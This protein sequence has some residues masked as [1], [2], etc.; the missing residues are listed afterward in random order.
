[1]RCPSAAE[2][3]GAWERGL[4]Q[5]PAERGLTLLGAVLPEAASQDLARLSIGRRDAYLLSL[6][7]QA[8]GPKL[9]S[10]ATCPACSERVEL[11]LSTQDLRALSAADASGVSEA[12]GDEL[13]LDVGDYAVHC[14]LPNT[15]DLLAVAET[16]EPEAARSA[17]VDRC[18]LT[19]ERRGEAIPPAELPPGVAEAVVA[20]MSEADQQADVR[21]AMACPGCGHRWEAAFDILS[22]LWREL[23]AWAVRTLHEIHALASAYGWSERQILELSPARR[24]AYLELVAG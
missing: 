24:R 2:L 5:A 16:K 6:R 9:Q 21:L 20:R 4:G 18:F 11:S 10:L 12:A 14:R 19:V 17:L 8:F 23:G 15:L 1:M 7:E 3:L 13:S 22:Y